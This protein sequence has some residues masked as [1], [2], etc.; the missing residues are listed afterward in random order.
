MNH[1]SRPTRFCR[2]WKLRT[3]PVEL[4]TIKFWPLS[5]IDRAVTEPYS[6]PLLVFSK[7]LAS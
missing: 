1:S 7:S 4:A 5:Y 6:R 3:S 2:R